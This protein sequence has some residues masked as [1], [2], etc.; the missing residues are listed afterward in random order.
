MPS[1]VLIVLVA[2]CLAWISVL[3]LAVVT[4]LGTAVSAGWI[5][6]GTLVL[7][8]VVALVVMFREIRQAPE[9]PDYFAEIEPS[10][11]AADRLTFSGFDF[12][13]GEALAKPTVIG[14]RA[15]TAGS[16]ERIRPRRV[17]S[18]QDRPRTSSR[19]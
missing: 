9:M 1:K 3:A 6:G 12:R 15:M 19:S 18:R 4:I 13:T 7:G 10:P 16:F 11:A 17:G 2:T 14:S 8:L 5:I